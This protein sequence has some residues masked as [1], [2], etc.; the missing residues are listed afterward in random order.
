MKSY[1][2]LKRA[3]DVVGV[4]ALA[5]KLK[6]SPALVYKW[7]Q[8]FDPDDPDVSGA[9]NPLDRLTDIVAET[10]DVEVVQWLCHQAGGFF[11]RNPSVAA[12]R[13]GTELLAN[14]QRL[15]QEFSE[16]L[17][18][19]T[20]SIEDD[21]RIENKEADRIRDSWEDF[22]RTVEEFAVACEQGLFA[23][24]RSQRGRS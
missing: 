4:K 16:L 22:K 6:L 17:M 24:M 20:R 9:R 7:C 5:A 11:V 2:V 12:G 14:T 15:V 13:T 1:E 10:G 19:V 23:Q 3:A 8:E 21:G 18:T